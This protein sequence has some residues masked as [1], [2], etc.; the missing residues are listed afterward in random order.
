MTLLAALAAEQPIPQGLK[1]LELIPALALI[2][3]CG[4]GVTERIPATKR[5]ALLTSMQF[6]YDRRAV[7][8]FESPV[9]NFQFRVWK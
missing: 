2:Q 7:S 4:G 5:S 3:Y 8:S 6:M 9:S 1:A